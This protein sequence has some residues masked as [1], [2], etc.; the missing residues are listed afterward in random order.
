[1]ESKGRL[2]KSSI[3]YTLRV[4]LSGLSGAGSICSGAVQVQRVQ[5]AR[6][7]LSL[8][9]SSSLIRDE[10]EHDAKNKKDLRRDLHDLRVKMK[11]HGF[12]CFKMDKCASSKSHT[13]LPWPIECT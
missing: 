3:V 2:Q 6:L 11:R 13:A 1:M 10:L 8:A 5:V 7:L 12:S 4:F 9:S